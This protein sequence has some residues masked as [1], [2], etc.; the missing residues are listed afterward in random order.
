M[1]TIVLGVKYWTVVVLGA[2]IVV[3]GA[4]VVSVNSI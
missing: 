2:V 4:G 3:T 1:R